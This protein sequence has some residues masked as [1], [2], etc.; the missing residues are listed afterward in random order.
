M[1]AIALALGLFLG[2]ALHAGPGAADQDDPRLEA[3]FAQLEAAP[4]ARAAQEVEASIWHIWVQSNDQVIGMLMTQGLAAMTRNDLRA[5]LGKFD[6]IVKIA[7][8]FAEGWNKRATVHYLLGTYAE[9]LYDIERTLK[10]E[11]RHFGAL[12]GRGLV[13]LELD[14]Q[15]GAL[16]SFE[17]ALKIHPNLSGA[18]RNAEALRREIQ[19]HE[20]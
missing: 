18:S 2:L 17:S 5:A 19:R 6:Q 10:L 15:A 8:G 12:S 4:H 1:T 7:P 11:P 13:L 16:E 14:Q 9:S 20:I 3:L